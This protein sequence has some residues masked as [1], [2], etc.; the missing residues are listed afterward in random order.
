[1]RVVALSALSRE[2]G[3]PWTT[4]SGLSDVLPFVKEAA[5]A[6]FASGLL[7]FRKLNLF[8]RAAAGCVGVSRTEALVVV[9]VLRV[10]DGGI[11]REFLLVDEIGEIV[12]AL[13]QI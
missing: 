10:L 1:V 3:E 12:S 8:L 6:S 11:R 4:L 9:I 5:T 2:G 13:L 7:R